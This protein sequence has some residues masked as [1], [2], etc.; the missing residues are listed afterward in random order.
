M[1]IEV[2]D[3]RR[4]ERFT[5]VEPLTGTFGPADVSVLNLG[6][7]GIAI[8]HPQPV[9]IGTR[10]KLSC[11]R[12]DVTIVVPATIVWSHLNPGSGG[13]VYC[14]GLKLDAA[15]PQYALAINTLMR[16]GAL[17]QDVGSLERKKQRMREREEA[18]K[19][20]VRHVPA[21]EPPPA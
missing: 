6:L 14:S 10:A 18:R 11:R 5:V 4:G 3:L 17:R 12:G 19:S 20:L 8:S 16:G 13:M 7:G 9:R 21:S 2:V 1:T 15:D